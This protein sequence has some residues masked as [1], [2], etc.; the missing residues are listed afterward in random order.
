M[1][2]GAS[3]YEP[4]LFAYGDPAIA[5]EDEKCRSVRLASEFLQRANCTRA[6]LS[7]SSLRMTDLAQY[8][9]F[10]EELEADA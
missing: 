3:P 1:L 6:D 8:P 2:N 4:A 10:R 7:E 9:T 5:H